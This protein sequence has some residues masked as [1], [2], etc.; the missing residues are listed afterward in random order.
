MKAILWKSRI[1][2]LLPL[3]VAVGLLASP[4]WAELSG[5]TGYGVYET[6]LENVDDSRSYS[7]GLD[8]V[9]A[10]VASGSAAGKTRCFVRCEDG[11]WDGSGTFGIQVNMYNYTSADSNHVLTLAD[12]GNPY[13][14]G[15]YTVYSQGLKVDPTPDGSGNRVVWFSMTGNASNAGD[16][17]T[18]T[19]DP[20]F[21]AA[22]TPVHQ[23]T[24]PGCWEVEWN[25][26]TGQAFYAGKES[27]A[28]S[29]PHA[30]FIYTG[31]AL[32]EVVRVEGYS[33]GFAFDPNG[34][35]YAGTYTSIGPADQ[36]YVLMFN[37]AQVA[38]AISSGATL[39]ATSGTSIAL[40]SPN[41]VFLGANDLEC[42]EDGNIYIT[43]NGAWDDTY[44]SD[45]GYVYRIDA[46]S[47]TTPTSMSLIASGTFTDDSDWQKALA[48]DG[49][50]NL[51]AGGYYDPTNSSQIGNR[52]YVDQDYW[53]G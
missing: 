28:W 29:D 37:A 22:G 32:Q 9:Y 52:L 13:G 5:S 26:A 25:P 35:L 42:D 18:V 10:Q 51:A 33:C 12:A 48:F 36:Q 8:V 19:V 21:S 2:P 34:N 6:T 44:D 15:M 7:G 23:F 50:S 46:W 53:F 16:W 4:A 24:Q 41:A 31:G 20:D 45:V 27:D 3:V 11:D 38:N 14:S 1:L 40:P 17:Y 30:I 43:A 47:G 49:S 39:T